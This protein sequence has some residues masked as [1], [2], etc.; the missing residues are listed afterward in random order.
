MLQGAIEDI[1]SDMKRRMELGLADA[2]Q[3]MC[4]G[5][6]GG[7]CMAKETKSDGA[8]GWAPDFPA[9]EAC[10]AVAELVRACPAERRKNT[11]DHLLDALAGD[12]PDWSEMLDRVAERT[13]SAK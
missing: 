1:I 7:L 8:L 6:V 13:M 9:E 2:A 11:R 5:I 4:R 3:A 12:V 10:H